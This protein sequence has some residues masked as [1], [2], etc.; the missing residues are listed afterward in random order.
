MSVILI[1]L[2]VFRIEYRQYLSIKTV[3]LVA[4]PSYLTYA[5]IAAV[6]YM[7]NLSPS[8]DYYDYVGDDGPIKANLTAREMQGVVMLYMKKGQDGDLVINWSGCIGMTIL[9]TG[10]TILIGMMI[11]C[12]W[13]I[14]QTIK[15]VS[16][17]MF[18]GNC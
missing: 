10:N 6:N 2:A 13:K 1:H 3:S 9:M 18:R 15:N 14:H 12:G 8:E 16:N 7:I 4:I 17:S 11:F 5:F